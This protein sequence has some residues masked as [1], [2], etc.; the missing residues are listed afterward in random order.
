M[1]TIYSG[2]LLLRLYTITTC[3][4]VHSAFDSLGTPS[5][6]M[7]TNQSMCSVLTS[8]SSSKPSG[9]NPRDASSRTPP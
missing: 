9:R 7:Q 3:F 5:L 8:S 2:F 4:E 6:S 1:A